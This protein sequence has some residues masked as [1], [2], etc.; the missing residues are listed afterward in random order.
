MILGSEL[1]CQLPD[2]LAV[3]DSVCAL[4]VEL[5]GD[6]DSQLRRAWEGQG[7]ERCLD[8]FGGYFVVWIHGG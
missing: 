8:F 4:F 7:V 5:A 6:V 3:N 1:G 2:G